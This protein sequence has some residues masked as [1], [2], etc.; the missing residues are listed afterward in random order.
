M[1]DLQDAICD[2]LAGAK[3][4]R[5]WANGPL[6]IAATVIQP[7]FELAP[8][9]HNR[10]QNQL[11]K[12]MNWPR[13]FTLGLH[14]ANAALAAEEDRRALAIHVFQQVAPRSKQ[15]RVPRRKNCELACWAAVWAH[16]L[17]CATDCPVHQA[18]TP[19]VEEYLAGKKQSWSQL[20]EAR[21]KLRRCATYKG[22]PHK[23]VSWGSPPAHHAVV[24]CR[25]LLES[26]HREDVIQAG[27][28]IREAAKVAAKVEGVPG[29]VA[30]VL[31]VGRRLGLL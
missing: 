31:E 30:F 19:V 2:R 24:S 12:R 13:L 14:G 22:D 7:G 9:T 28:C 18:I 16:T 26:L 5:D 6:H 11:I 17:V 20:Q 3:I 21:P 10:R 1:T 29:A 8:G 25:Y 15:G 27:D 4:S 23:A